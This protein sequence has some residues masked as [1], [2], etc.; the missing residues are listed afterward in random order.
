[1]PFAIGISGFYLLIEN[2]RPDSKHV[3]DKVKDL[4]A[5]LVKLTK[6]KVSDF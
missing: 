3:C 1:M 6:H 2:E 4:L 5:V